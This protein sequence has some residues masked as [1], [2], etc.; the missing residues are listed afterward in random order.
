MTHTPAAGWIENRAGKGLRLPD[1]RELWAYRELGFFLA[2]RDLKVRY[3]QAIFGAG[4]AVLQP[5]AT[6]AVFT[7]VFHRLAGM[8][9]DGLPY[10]LFA[11]V[12][13]SVWTY[14]SAAV[15]KATQVLVQNSALVSKV[16]FP[17]LIAPAAAVVPGVLDLVISLSLLI[18]LIPIYGVP[19]RWTILTT[20]LLII[21]L[22]TAALGTGLWLGTLNVRFRDV[23][24]GVVLLLQLW[25][26]ISP[27][28]YPSSEVPDSWQAVYFLNPM[29]GSIES[30]R[31]AMLGA[32]WP[33]WLV[34]ESVAV[35]VIMLVGG[36]LYFLRQERRFADVI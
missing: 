26:F 16:Y 14:F 24:H 25:L 27:V 21:P 2:L 22:V 20:P 5:L 23:D 9:S 11:Y 30:F 32:P 4:W 34:M 31:W 17:R 3:K 33:G 36:V 15:T 29:A 28:V 1:L 35:A 18:V 7:V 12:G 13:V 6:A 10:V 8:P 19:L